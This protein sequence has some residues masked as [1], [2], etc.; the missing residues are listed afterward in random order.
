MT[1]ISA[2]APAPAPRPT[3]KAP[4]WAKL[5]LVIFVLLLIGGAAF[6]GIVLGK[7]LGSTEARDVQVVRSIVREEQV[8]LLTMGLTDNL[9]ERGEGL[10][11]FGW[12]DLP[13][14]ERQKLIR[15]DFDAKL[16]IDGKD[17]SI[18]ALGDNRYRVSIPEFKFLGYDNPEF[19]VAS[20]NN[21]L[22]SWTTPEIDD[23]DVLEKE[24]STKAVASHIDGARPLLEE[25]AR[26]FYTDILTA[27]DPDISVDFTFAPATPVSK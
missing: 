20:E 22:L 21:G 4:L 12:F 6:G 14:T 15:Y 17:V 5:L 8:I 25:Q 27:V 19:S 24:L 7:L 16:G 11:V 26:K 1:A 10:S 2:P 3:K 23:L 13:G 9:D 18:T